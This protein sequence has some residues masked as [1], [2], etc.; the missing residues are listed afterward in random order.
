[1][2]NNNNQ[3]SLVWVKNDLIEDGYRE[4]LDFVH[5]MFSDDDLLMDLMKT[6]GE[7]AKRNMMVLVT[8]GIVTGKWNSNRTQ[9]EMEEFIN[10]L[11][12]VT[13]QQVLCYEELNPIS[14][15]NTPME[16]ESYLRHWQNIQID[17]IGSDWFFTATKHLTLFLNPDNIQKYPYLYE[18]VNIIDG[19]VAQATAYT[20]LNFKEAVIDMVEDALEQKEEIM[21]DG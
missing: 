12:K 5:K 2:L 4:L 19:L 13:P 14:S 20:K 1:M 21:E 3:N 7:Q 18:L 11:S 16:L 10:E 17:D 6:Y 9:I 15:R 8:D